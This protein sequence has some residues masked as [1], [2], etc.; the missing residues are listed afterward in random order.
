MKKLEE[1]ILDWKNRNS[2]NFVGDLMF[3]DQPITFGYG[4]DSLHSKT[5]YARIF[6]NV[7]NELNNS[8]VSIGNFE[9]IIKPKIYSNKFEEWEMC[10]DERI[11]RELL[12]A[13]I[14]IVSLAN[15]HSMDYGK[16]G[17]LFM[18]QTLESYGIRIIGLKEK[19]Y[20]IIP[21]ANKKIAVVAACYIREKNR[22]SLYLHN[23]SKEELEKICNY[24]KNTDYKIFY[25]HW[26]SEFTK[27]PT[28]KQLYIANEIINCGFDVIIGHHPH[29]LQ[30]EYLINSKPV[31]F[32]LGNFV[33][34]YWQKRCRNTCILQ[35][36]IDK[37]IEFKKINCHINK[38]GQPYPTF[39]EK[40]ILEQFNN[41][42]STE[43]YQNVE[44]WKMRFE[45]MSH[46]VS[47]FHK[48][49]DK[50]GLS[51]WMA[52]R[53]KYVITNFGKEFA[54]PELIYEEYKK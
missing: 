34:D 33:S 8:A 36:N 10:C 21:I 32:S 53:I 51:R 28:K 37:K 1:M 42:I 31:F 14:S 35:V 6:S 12:K 45:Y 48:I 38:R 23:P 11:C 20:E 30:K 25:V 50:K 40:I 52:R 44:R 19:P 17:F 22:D 39:D 41:K 43:K 7:F 47:N 5:E 27:F 2:I 49:R 9:S 24:I 4:V 54:N 26:G 3:G 16:D 18:K 13:N 15:N 29:I 46:F